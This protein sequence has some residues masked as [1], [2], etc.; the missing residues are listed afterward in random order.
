MQKLVQRFAFLWGFLFWAGTVFGQPGTMTTVG[1]GFDG[2]PYAVA[3]D[4]AGNLYV[5]DWRNGAIRK[6]SPG[7]AVSTVL[8][9]MNYPEDVAVDA[10]GNLYIA[11][12]HDNEV[13]KVSSTGSVTIIAGRGQ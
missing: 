12:S 3:V 4:S 7:G 13:L 10:A 8:T 1:S 6:V 11:D 9:G 2:G 5:A